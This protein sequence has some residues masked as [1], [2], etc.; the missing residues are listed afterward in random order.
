MLSRVRL[1]PTSGG[2][3]QPCVLL[4][5]SSPLEKG[6]GKTQ[7]VPI[8]VLVVPSFPSCWASTKSC[9]SERKQESGSCIGRPNVLHK[10]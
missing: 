4:G 3:L 7:W 10:P 6:M 9:V 2:I 8:F 1:S 5:A